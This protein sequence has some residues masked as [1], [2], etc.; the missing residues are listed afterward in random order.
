VILLEFDKT[1]GDI[2]MDGAGKES[3]D[4]FNDIGHGQRIAFTLML[5]F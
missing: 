2:I 3:T 1:K 5:L 4:L